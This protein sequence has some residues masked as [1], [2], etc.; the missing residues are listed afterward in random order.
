[1]AN[2]SQT[3]VNEEFIR[4]E[5]PFIITDGM[6]DWDIMMTDQ[7]WFDNITEVCV[8]KNCENSANFGQKLKIAKMN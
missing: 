1:M 6:D 2:V 3:L 4:R 5:K 7:F 8:Q